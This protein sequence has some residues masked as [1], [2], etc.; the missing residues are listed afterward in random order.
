MSFYLPIL[1][2]AIVVIVASYILKN[3][4]PNYFNEKGKLLAQKEDIKE[5]TEKLRA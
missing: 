4:L 2:N 3:Y 1:I 5:I